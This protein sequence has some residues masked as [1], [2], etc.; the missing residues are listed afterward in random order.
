M[1]TKNLKKEMMR[2]TKF[3]LSIF[4]MVLL[5]WYIWANFYYRW[6]DSRLSEIVAKKYLLEHID[7]LEKDTEFIAKKIQV[8]KD[9]SYLT[10]V[11]QMRHKATLG[12]LY[13][14][15]VYYKIT[16]DCSL[17]DSGCVAV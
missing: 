16:S 5:I 14:V 8:S 1:D 12:V 7:S 10:A 2:G 4:V 15:S 6:S 9:K 13:E 3:A 17:V 11:V